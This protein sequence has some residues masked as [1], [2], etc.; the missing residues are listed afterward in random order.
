MHT[1]NN[2]LLKNDLRSTIEAAY[3]Y[4]EYL[5]ILKSGDEQAH[6]GEWLQ[7]ETLRQ[8][9]LFVRSESQITQKVD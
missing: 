2:P 1:S 7:L 3:F 5:C 6:V 8:A 4:C 9:L